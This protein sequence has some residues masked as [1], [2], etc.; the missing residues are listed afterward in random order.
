MGNSERIWSNG[1]DCD[2]SVIWLVVAAIVGP[3][4]H[5]GHLYAEFNPI[6]GQIMSYP[7]PTVMLIM[8][9]QGQVGIDLGPGRSQP[10]TLIT[11]TQHTSS[12]RPHILT[13]TPRQVLHSR[14]QAYRPLRRVI[15]HAHI[16]CTA[17]S[18]S[19]PTATAYSN[20]THGPETPDHSSR[21]AGLQD[22][23]CVG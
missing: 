6:S 18:Q 16:D 2:C 3:P 1:N 22:C 11:T 15:R 13:V 8:S 10:S 12:E 5:P 19:T 4:P 21:I 23:E 20:N 9:S 17:S 7:L 14:A